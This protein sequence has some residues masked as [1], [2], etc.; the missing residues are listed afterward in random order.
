MKRIVGHYLP[1]SPA[2]RLI[3]DLLHFAAKVPTVPVQR[4]MQLGELAQARDLVQDDWPAGSPKPRWP[5]LFLKAFALTAQEIPVLRQA[6]IRWPW[7]RMYQHPHSVVS[8]AVSKQTVS[9]GPDEEVLFGHIHH[10]EDLALEQIET[11]LRQFKERPANE[12]G[13]MRRAMRIARL[14]RFLRRLLWWS[15]LEWSGPMRANHLGTFGLSVYS[16]LGAESLH[17]LSPLTTCLT[18]GPVSAKGEVTARIIYDHRAMDG[19]QIA[20]A[21]ARMEQLLQ[22]A[23]LQETRALA[24]RNPQFPPR[25][26]A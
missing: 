17:P 20:R 2:R 18:F 10:P 26:T 5:S 4:Q 12:F 22:G 19:S 14:P 24:T 6:L 21:L 25:Q 1:V 7:E 8:V 9:D 3:C 15:A 11:R 23:L 13:V 16:G